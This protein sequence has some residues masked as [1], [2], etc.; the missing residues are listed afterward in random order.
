MKTVFPGRIVAGV[1]RHAYKSA[2]AA[3]SEPYVGMTAESLSFL[4]LI[5]AVIVKSFHNEY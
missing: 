5:F 3:H 4:I 2:P 1:S